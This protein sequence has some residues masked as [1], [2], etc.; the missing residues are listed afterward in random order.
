M[1]AAGVPEV[2]ATVYSNL[3]M[4]AG[5]AWWLLIHGGASGIGT[6]ATQWANAIGA[7]VIVTTGGPGSRS[8]AGASRLGRN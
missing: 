5:S 4:T 3:A 6:F 1:R 7:K 8:S 2:A